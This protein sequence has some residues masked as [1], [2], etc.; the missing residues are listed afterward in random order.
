MPKITFNQKDA[1]SVPHNFSK[2]TYYVISPMH[3]NS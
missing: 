2:I 1:H 3:T